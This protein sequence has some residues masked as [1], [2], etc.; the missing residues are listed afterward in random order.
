MFI[1]QV[2]QCLFIFFIIGLGRLTILINPPDYFIY[3]KIPDKSTSY[4]VSFKHSLKSS[5]LPNLTGQDF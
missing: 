1:P 4:P 3:D 2:S 5:T